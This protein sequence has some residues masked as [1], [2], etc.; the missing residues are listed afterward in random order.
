MKTKSMFV[1]SDQLA[2]VCLNALRESDRVEHAGH[3]YYAY[4]QVGK[5]M[6]EVVDKNGTQY[7]ITVEAI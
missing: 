5:R 4:S 3:A 1:Y 7:L 6:L 2:D